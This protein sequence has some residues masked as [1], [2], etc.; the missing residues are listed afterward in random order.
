M[1]KGTTRRSLAT[2]KASHESK[3]ETTC[4]CASSSSNLK[5]LLS[6]KTS[7]SSETDR[8]PHFKPKTC[9]A[10]YPNNFNMPSPS[11]SSPSSS[12]SAA[13]EEPRTLYFAYGSN[14]STTQMNDRCPSSRLHTS[15]LAV[16][17]DYEW[18]IA[19]RGYASVR[20]AFGKAVYGLLFE[21]DEE[22]EDEL[23]WYEGVSFERA[24]SYYKEL[25]WV[26]LLSKD[27]EEANGDRIE[28]RDRV[29]A[30]VY[31]DCTDE[32]GNLGDA[33]AFRLKRGVEES[34]KLGLKLG[35]SLGKWMDQIMGFEETEGE[36]EEGL[37]QRKKCGEKIADCREIGDGYSGIYVALGKEHPSQ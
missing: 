23:D 22:S 33:Y 16:L 8:K 30:L 7:L 9:S 14:L 20:P 6:L 25:V 26:D 36:E 32:E 27:A 10:I 31:I 5:L 12:S 18:F 4:P 13:S 35:T 21:L 15:P 3:R 37:R 34:E 24:G 11:S 29:K 28:G 19:S 17:H 2:S 1:Y